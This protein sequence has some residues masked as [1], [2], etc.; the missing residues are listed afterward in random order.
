MG[1]LLE[2]AVHIERDIRLKGILDGDKEVEVR[3]EVTISRDPE[4]NFERTIEIKINEPDLPVSEAADREEDAGNAGAAHGPSI[5]EVPPV[6][7]FVMQRNK[8][9]DLYETASAWRACTRGI[10][11]RRDRRYSSRRKIRR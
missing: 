1:S 2:K 5:K 8:D 4:K 3:K 7:G 10:S 11:E 6:I 9:L